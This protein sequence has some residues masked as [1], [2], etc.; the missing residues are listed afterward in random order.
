MFYK[1][2]G[3][4]TPIEFGRYQGKTL[5]EVAR[6]DK[7]YLEWFIEEIDNVSI[8]DELLNYQEIQSLSN[9]RIL[10]DRL[11]VEEEMW[12]DIAGTNDPDVIVAPMLPKLQDGQEFL[13]IVPFKRFKNQHGK[14]VPRPTPIKEGGKIY[15]ERDGGALF[16]VEEFRVFDPKNPFKGLTK[17]SSPFNKTALKYVKAD[18]IETYK[19]KLEEGKI[20]AGFISTFEDFEPFYE[21]QTPNRTDAQGNDIFRISV[22]TEFNESE[23]ID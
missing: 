14:E 12:S 2:Y 22:V 8:D 5:L 13:K 18:E 20:F 1:I 17:N 4:N 9:I 3:V 23:Y 11:L 21:G 7:S 15:E 19:T 10:E 6:E 16:L